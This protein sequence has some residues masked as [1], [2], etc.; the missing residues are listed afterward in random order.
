[1]AVALAALP[2]MVELLNRELLC[3]RFGLEDPEE[4]ERLRAWLWSMRTASADYTEL[5]QYTRFAIVLA[6]RGSPWAVV[7]SLVLRRLRRNLETEVRS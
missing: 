7:G 4:L 2:A 3:A 1:V 5:E 6:S